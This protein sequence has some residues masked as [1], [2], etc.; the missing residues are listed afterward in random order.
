[1]YSDGYL[2][3][4][5]SITEE[6]VV[7]LLLVERQNRIEQPGWWQMAYSIT[8]IL[9]LFPSSVASENASGSLPCNICNSSLLDRP[10][11][12]KLM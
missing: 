1:M 5:A 2:H 8:M 3:K 9:R 4:K 10:D 11:T 12:A 7:D 6:V